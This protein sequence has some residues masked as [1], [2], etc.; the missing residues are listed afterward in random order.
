MDNNNNNNIT[1]R[2]DHEQYKFTKVHYITNTLISK[3][4][5]IR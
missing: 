3:A 2:E 1:I 4:L 5:P